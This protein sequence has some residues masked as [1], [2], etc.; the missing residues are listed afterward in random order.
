MEKDVYSE[1]L[2]LEKNHWWFIG[3]RKIFFTLLDQ[4]F[5]EKGGM[6]ILD[7]GCGPGE[8]I[9]PLSKYGKVFAL[10]FSLNALEYCL[11]RGY[12][13]LIDGDATRLPVKN[14]TFDVIS[15]F[16]T[17]EHI[18][19]DTATLKECHRLLEDKGLII[20]TVPAYNF[21][22]SNN[23]RAAHH[24]RRYTTSGIRR[25]VESV[26]F[27][28]I[29]LTYINTWLFPIIVCALFFI[30][31]KEALFPVSNPDK[32]NISFPI[33]KPLNTVLTTIFC[34]ESYLLKRISFPV[35]HSLICIAEKKI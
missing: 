25:K 19:N 28:V 16:D 22:Y 7:V 31:L 3:R 29:K 14:G 15:L 26:G 2:T 6:R 11:E 33:P 30:K 17:I 4:C 24:K 1:F 27:R 8:M 23:D 9:Q 5:D 21:L 35:G 12:R 18:D 20:I 10:D 32:T 34:S 13:F